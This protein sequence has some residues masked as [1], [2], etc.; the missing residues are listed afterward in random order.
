MITIKD[1]TY[2]LLITDCGDLTVEQGGPAI[3]R[4]EDAESGG[5]YVYLVEAGVP[6]TIYGQSSG[7]DFDG[8]TLGMTVNGISFV[9]AYE[10]VQS[11]TFEITATLYRDA[12]LPVTYLE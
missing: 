1:R 7:N 12:A 2:C 8:A 10:S 4:I 11:S 3:T 5:K 9:V 6:F